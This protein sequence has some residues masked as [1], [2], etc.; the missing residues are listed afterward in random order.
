MITPAPPPAE[1]I[2]RRCV[3]ALL[4]WLRDVEA[5]Q[6][7]YQGAARERFMRLLDKYDCVIERIDHEK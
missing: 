1:R 3:L 4:R 7:G 6:D 5:K 2:A